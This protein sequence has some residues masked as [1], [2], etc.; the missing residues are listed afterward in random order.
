MDLH[1]T[2]LFYSKNSQYS[3]TLLK[4][5]ENCGVNIEKIIGYKLVCIDNKKI[6]N[7]IL[8]SKDINIQYVPCL[9]KVFNNGNVEQ[10]NYKELYQ[11]VS[12]TVDLHNKEVQ[13]QQ[14]HNIKHVIRMDQEESLSSSSSES[15]IEEIPKKVK[16]V[17]KEHKKKVKK[18]HKKNEKKTTIIESD[19]ESESESEHENIQISSL[20]NEPNE[21]PSALK[22]KSDDLVSS[23]LKMQQEREADEKSTSR[24]IGPIHR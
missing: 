10:Y 19:F 23:A 18:E 21:K 8:N 20:T 17:K 15:E 9:I 16:K 7:T 24:P 4:Y 13:K 14:V 22:K 2:I 11:L 3:N 5:I 6:R 1:K 12:Y